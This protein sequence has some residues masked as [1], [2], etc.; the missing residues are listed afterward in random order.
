MKECAITIDGP[1]SERD[2]TLPEMLTESLQCE[3]RYDYHWCSI[4]KLMGRLSYFAGIT[5]LPVLAFLWYQSKDGPIDGPFESLMLLASVLLISLGTYTSEAYCARKRKQRRL[6]TKLLY[7]PV[8]VGPALLLMHQE[9]H[10]EILTAATHI[11]KVHLPKLRV[12]DYAKFNDRQRAS[13]C[14]VLHSDD[15]DLALAAIS[16]LQYVGDE[17]AIIPLQSILAQEH[18]SEVVR[19]A[20]ETSIYAITLRTASN[21]Q[22]RTLLRA[23]SSVSGVSTSLLRSSSSGNDSAI[24]QLVRA[25]K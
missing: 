24:E 9:Q 18:I 1:I 22:A 2:V 11:L 10:G 19:D 7:H 12:K 23:G 15:R 8:A 17:R 3:T 4:V 21:R 13:L 6:I 20:V 16:A 25:V 14:H 5:L